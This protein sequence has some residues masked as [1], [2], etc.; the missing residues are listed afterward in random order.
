MHVLAAAECLFKKR[1][2]CILQKEESLKHHHETCKQQSLQTEAS[3]Q[4]MTQLCRERLVSFCI[5][6]AG[7]WS[8]PVTQLAQGMADRTLLINKCS[9]LSPE[10][11]LDS[12]TYKHLTLQAYCYKHSLGRQRCC[13]EL[14]VLRPGPWTDSSGQLNFNQ[15]F[16]NLF[17]VRKILKDAESFLVQVT[18]ISV[19][20]QVQLVP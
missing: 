7:A 14:I 19:V 16:V 5:Y 20:G 1:S 13:S 10:L 6:Q 12:G 3:P 4:Y 15:S 2:F 11:I 8:Y 17:F 9:I 18:L